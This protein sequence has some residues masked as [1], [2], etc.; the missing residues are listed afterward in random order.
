MGAG[1]SYET[2]LSEQVIKAFTLIPT[3][4]CVLVGVS[5][6]KFGHQVRFSGDSWTDN[7][8][9]GLWMHV[10]QNVIWDVL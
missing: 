2:G 1:S 9:R 7:N 10:S 8:Y 4:F 3:V 6:W 5:G